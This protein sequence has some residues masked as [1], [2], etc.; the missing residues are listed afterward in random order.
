MGVGVGGRTV[1]W[2]GGGGVGYGYGE[3]RLVDIL[4]VYFCL[5]VGCMI[6]LMF[7][8]CFLVIF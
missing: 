4:L 5:T 3:E 7:E 8:W 2:V 6:I 1:F